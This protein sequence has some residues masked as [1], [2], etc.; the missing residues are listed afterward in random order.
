MG[1]HFQGHDGFVWF[2]GVV[3]DRNDP[4][5][6]GRVRV[7][8]I[9]HHTD[10]KLKIPTEDLP[11]AWVMSSIQT[12]SMNGMGY[13]PGFMVEGTWVVGFFRDADELQE[14]IVIGTLPGV[15]ETLGDP[16]KGF[17]DP[18]RRDLNPDN[19]GYTQSIYPR[20]T[21]EPD[22][23]RL[24]RNFQVDNTIV[25]SK[26]ASVV[27]GIPT[28]NDDSWDEPE[29][30]YNATYPKNHVYESESGHTIEYDD[31]SGAQRLGRYSS[32]GTFEEIDAIGNKVVKVLGN[33]YQVVKGTENDFVAGDMNLTV[34]GTLNI[35][36]KD[37]NIEVENNYSEE[38]GNN[39]E[40]KI[41][42][43]SATDIFGVVMETYDNTYTQ[44]IRGE[45]DI[46]YGSTFVEHIKGEITKNYLLG[47]KEY[48]GTSI[49]QHIGTTSK[50]FVNTDFEQHIT[51]SSKILVGATLD[52]D[53]GTDITIDGTTVNI[54][55][56]TKGA[57]R[58]DDTAIGTDPA[59][60]AHG[61]EITSTI[62]AASSSV[63]IGDG[64]GSM[65][66]PTAYTEVTE[67]D[68]VEVLLPEIS[69]EEPLSA[70][71]G[72]M[73]D[74]IP[75][76]VD[77]QGNVVSLGP[78]YTKEQGAVSVGQHSPSAADTDYINSP[79]GDCTRASLGELSEFHESGRRGASA[80]NYSSYYKDKGGWSYGLYQLETRGGSYK[81]FETWLSK[82]HNGFTDFY[83]ELQRAGGEQAAR[84]ATPKG[85]WGT[86]NKSPNNAFQA[87]WE[88]LA[89]KEETKDRFKQCQKMY[90]SGKYY[91]TQVERIK[92]KWGI[93]ICGE[94]R[95]NGLQDA[96][97]STAIQYGANN[98]VFNTTMA[99]LLKKSKIKTNPLYKD[100]FPNGRPATDFTDK[101]IITEM[102][103]YKIESVPT[104]FQ[105]S[106]ELHPGLY[107]RFNAEKSQALAMSAM[108]TN[109]STT[110]SNVV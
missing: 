52:I 53:S 109:T 90:S 89:T 94:P 44:S 39:K 98:S 71:V 3:E 81:A 56:G 61:S 14:P 106:P 1:N 4:T 8:C 45:V 5:K 100:T 97:W 83:E 107:S 21:G 85:G 27:Q 87:K 54:N 101:E 103:D 2:T 108:P 32:S 49:E 78:T 33:H 11:W 43:T 42:G 104:R 62:N 79:P 91:N 10:D 59:H 76:G 16:D 86:V 24:A 72:G 31:T 102:Y 37:L 22:T 51:G 82:E 48:I 20:T 74:T 96:V 40:I 64:A 95:S 19:E 34:N 41:E 55:Q 73:G 63:K 30:T 46:R 28:A 9:G 77:A 18:N 57:A 70:T 66:T 26:K 36:C 60:A 93:D 23:N 69:S 15:P 47:V 75:Q 13:T 92:K 84:T 99:R 67:T 12:P 29:T 105:S 7:R 88:E 58:L 25:G 6:L 38:V 35:K 65:T 110:V 68:L 80:I 17:N 50:I